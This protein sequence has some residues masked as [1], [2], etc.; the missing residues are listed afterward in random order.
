MTVISVNRVVDKNR[1]IEKTEGQGG[2]EAQGDTDPRKQQRYK[3]GIDSFKLCP[4]L[5]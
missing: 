4:D 1:I 2:G 3:L 5:Y